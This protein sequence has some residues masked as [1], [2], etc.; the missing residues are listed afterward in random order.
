MQHWNLG[1]VEETIEKGEKQL[2]KLSIFEV[3][4]SGFFS[5]FWVMPFYIKVLAILLVIIIIVFSVIY[6]HEFSRIKSES[7]YLMQIIE[8]DRKILDYNEWL[9]R[10]LKED[11]RADALIRNILAG[12]GI[13]NGTPYY[14]KVKELID[15]LEYDINDKLKP[16]I[17]FKEDTVLEN[18]NI[19]KMKEYKVINNKLD[20]AIA[21]SNTIIS[22][23]IKLNR[24][25]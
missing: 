23:K 22:T 25:P 18:K 15:K 8:L 7:K 2:M 16:I 9:E 11:N 13:L 3:D 12:K 14:Y 21:K 20:K 1:E 17:R 4:L 6:C 10:R 5:S 24:K 19:V